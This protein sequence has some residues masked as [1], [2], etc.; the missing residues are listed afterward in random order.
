MIIDWYQIGLLRDGQ[1][2]AE[3][4]PNDLMRKMDFFS[5]L[6]PIVQVVAFFSAVGHDPR[7]LSLAVVNDETAFS[8]HHQISYFL[9]RKLL[10]T[11]KMFSQRIMRACGRPERLA[12]DHGCWALGIL[13]TFTKIQFSSQ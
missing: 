12:E 4:S 1:L 11:Y 9:K 6:F 7:Y 8:P 5:I 13:K 3:E 10:T 2:L